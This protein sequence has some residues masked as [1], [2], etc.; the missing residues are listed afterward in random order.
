M[1]QWGNSQS[2]KHMKN[3]LSLW[4]FGVTGSQSI[5]APLTCLSR[6][7]EKIPP[8]TV[9]AS[10]PHPYTDLRRDPVLENATGILSKHAVC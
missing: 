7:Q 1:P 8:H 3:V 4:L 9:Q 10:S 6:A 5:K 2:M